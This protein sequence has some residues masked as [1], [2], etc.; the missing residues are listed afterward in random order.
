LN[1]P[2]HLR[3]PS[4]TPLE[5]AVPKSIRISI[6]YVSI[7]SLESALTG[8]SQLT[9]NTATSNPLECALTRHSPLTSLECALT[10]NAGG[11]PFKPNVFLSATR[12]ST[13]RPLNVPMRF[14]HPEWGYGK[15]RRSQSPVFRI[16]FQVPYP[17]SPLPATLTK[18]AGVYINNSHSG[19][20][21]FQPSTV[22]RR[23]RLCRDR[24]LPVQSLRFHPGEK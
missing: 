20:R 15:R 14:L 3:V 7:R 4:A 2:I 12:S 10:K 1:P 9:E 13:L 18:T 5:C 6:L 24:R 11:T 17:L 8:H 21:N 19:T 23:S 16:F 22:N